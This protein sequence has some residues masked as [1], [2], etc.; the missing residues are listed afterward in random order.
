MWGSGGIDQ[1]ILNW[2]KIGMSHQLY[3][4]PA[5]T[6]GKSPCYPHR[7]WV[8]SRAGLDCSR[9]EKSLTLPGIEP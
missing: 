9:R 2:H 5:S 3:V 8:G 1:F 6:V 7:G 4:L